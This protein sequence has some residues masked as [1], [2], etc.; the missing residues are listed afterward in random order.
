MQADVLYAYVLDTGGAAVC[1]PKLQYSP[2]SQTAVR[3]R[4]TKPP[5][6]VGQTARG[7]EFSL[8]ACQTM[9]SGCVVTV[10]RST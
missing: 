9:A 5:C 3:G 8:I 4:G 10:A 6:T 7:K 1:D 2:D